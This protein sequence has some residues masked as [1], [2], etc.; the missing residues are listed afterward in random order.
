MGEG[1]LQKTEKVL[2]ID[3]PS[4]SGKSTVAKMVAQQLGFI[5]VDTGA[6]FRALGLTAFLS[7]VDITNPLSVGNWI[8][9]IHF[10]YP[11]NTDELVVVNGENLTQKIREHH[12]SSLASQISRLP[13][14]RNYLL[15]FQRQLVKDFFCTMEGRD[16]G[17]VVFPYAF[18]KI[19]LTASP[20][21][22]AQRRFDELKSKNPQMKFDFQQ[23][24]RDV[25]DR[26]S[27]DSLRDLAPLKPAHDAFVLDSSPLQ[28]D[29]VVKVIC[30]RAAIH[31]SHH[32][33]TIS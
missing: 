19:F 6:M 31:A 27:A 20:E 9:N 12:V 2:A 18:C 10:T 3:G 33:L 8:Q 29:D 22:R 23:I 16:I 28:I 30:D 1:D 32:Q 13:V 21:V 11:G 4:G 26:D 14:V 7:G 24:L 25:V 17:T 15:H 5:Y